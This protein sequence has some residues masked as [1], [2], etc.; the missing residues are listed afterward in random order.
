M[1]R[2]GSLSLLCEGL[3]DSFCVNLSGPSLSFNQI[4]G[5]KEKILSTQVTSLANLEDGAFNTF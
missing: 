4:F 2:N 5:V 1:P 3:R